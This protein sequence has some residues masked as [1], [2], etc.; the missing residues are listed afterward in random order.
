MPGTGVAQRLV[1]LFTVALALVGG[2]ALGLELTEVASRGQPWFGAVRSGAWTAWPRGGAADADPYALAAYARTGQLPPAAGEGLRFL[3]E[4]DDGGA[5]LDARCAYTVAGPTPPAQF[6][7]LTRLDAADASPA[8]SDARA[9]FTSA[10][11]V[12]AADGSFTVSLARTARPGNWLP[13]GAAGRFTL[14]LNLY[15][16][17][18]TVALQMGGAPP[19][20]ARVSRVGCP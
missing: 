17:P 14:M 9:G 19:R 16:T 15:D 11:L 4:V 6:W 13:L 1:R 20:L 12:R 7:T 2:G 5:R 8:A 18:L 3:A 10:E